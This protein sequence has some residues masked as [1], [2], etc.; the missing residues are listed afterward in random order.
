MLCCF[1]FCCCLCVCVFCVLGGGGILICFVGDILFRMRFSFLCCVCVCYV[2]VV[3]VFK[4]CVV[5]CVCC[6][7]V[8]CV[9]YVV[10]PFFGMFSS[11]SKQTPIPRRECKTQIVPETVFF[12]LRLQLTFAHFSR[13]KGGSPQRSIGGRSQ[14]PP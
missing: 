10:V 3:F 1:A 12:H 13:L 8:F 7:C 9:C 14:I 6:F 2:G 11:I 5:V 4:V